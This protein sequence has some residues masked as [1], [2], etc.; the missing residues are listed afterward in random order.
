M[1]CSLNSDLHCIQFKVYLPQLCECKAAIL[2]VQSKF[3]QMPQPCLTTPQAI[4]MHVTTV[5][6]EKKCNYSIQ[7]CII[8]VF[9]QSFNIVIFP[10]SYFILFLKVFPDNFMRREVQA[11][12]VHCSFMDDG[13]KW[14]G[15]VRHLEVN[16]CASF[17]CTMH[18]FVIVYSL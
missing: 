8:M 5:C 18:K 13:C 9:G 3:N 7:N 10:T 14:K 17:T 2:Y 11:F 15:E 16:T 1:F 6:D 4:R 12:V